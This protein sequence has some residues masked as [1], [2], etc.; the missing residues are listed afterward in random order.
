MTSLCVFCGSNPGTR[1]E[2]ANA[3]VYLGAELA[4][5]GVTLVYGGGRVGLMGA[6]A[7][8]ALQGGGR[9]IGVMPQHLVDREIAHRGL[10]ELHIVG[11][12]HERKALM[13]QLSDAFVLLPGGFGSW[14]EFC[15]AVTWRQLGLHRK[16]LG[17][18]NTLGYYEPLLAM[19]RLSIE[20]GFVRSS[21]F[22]AMSIEQDA[23]ALLDRIALSM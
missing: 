22:D 11:S 20:D 12:M 23:S 18:L 3:A 21:L 5:R 10:T 15:E 17:I 19:I 7:D 14:D 16:P 6:V 13:I 9:V 2:Y 4:R 8:A 1:P